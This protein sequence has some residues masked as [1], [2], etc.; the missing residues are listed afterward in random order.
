MQKEWN[1][2][3]RNHEIQVTLKGSGLA[4]LY[5]D[6][7]LADSTNDIY[8]A[9]GEPTLVTVVDNVIIDAYVQMDEVEVR[10]NGAKVHFGALAATA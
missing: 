8:A 1:A 5:V 4:E 10:A 6:G 9:E 3:Y 2:I 7:E